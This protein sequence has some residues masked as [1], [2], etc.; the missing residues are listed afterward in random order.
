MVDSEDIKA[1]KD[2]LRKIDK[3]WIASMWLKV[4][5]DNPGAELGHYLRMVNSLPQYRGMGGSHIVEDIGDS[6]LKNMIVE[7]PEDDDEEDAEVYDFKQ[8]R[9][10]WGN[11]WPEEDL[12]AFQDFYDSF[13]KNYNLVTSQHIEFAKMAT[14]YNVRAK[15]ALS[16][17][18]VANAQKYTDM[19]DKMTKAGNI[20]P[21]QLS[22]ADIQGG[23][24]TFVI[25]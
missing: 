2:L 14:M 19:F 11:M 25:S 18:D 1:V 24:N 22:K 16:D 8:L 12:I 15:K 5:K 6:E 7:N 9:K 4:S 17:G 13:T 10:F 23:L 21:Q 20:Q 3:P